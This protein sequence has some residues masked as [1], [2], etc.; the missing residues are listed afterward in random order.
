LAAVTG[1]PYPIQKV[2]ADRSSFAVLPLSD[3]ILAGQQVIADRFHR[4]GLIPRPI[5]IRDAVWTP[6]R[7]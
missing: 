2:A 5:R 7:S 4:L 3:T 1:V 6:P